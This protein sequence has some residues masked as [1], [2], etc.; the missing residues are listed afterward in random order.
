MESYVGCMPVIRRS[1]TDDQCHVALDVVK[2]TDDRAADKTVSA[3]GEG[4]TH[5]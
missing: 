5:R 3:F 1:G 4:G 2:A